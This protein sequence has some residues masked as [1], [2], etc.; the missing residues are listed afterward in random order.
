MA[1]VFQKQVTIA[2]DDPVDSDYQQQIQR[3]KRANDV[4]ENIVMQVLPKHGNKLDIE[5]QTTQRSSVTAVRKNGS[6]VNSN[7][8]KVTVNGIEK[9]L[10]KEVSD[11][12]VALIK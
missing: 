12:L 2:A 10:N 6:V 1:L 4:L 8:I 9:M 3:L 7:Q 5:I 11:T